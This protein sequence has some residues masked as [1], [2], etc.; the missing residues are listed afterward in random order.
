MLSIWVWPFLQSIGPAFM[1]GRSGC[2]LARI[3][4]LSAG[5]RNRDGLIILNTWD[6]QGNSL[7]HPILK[8]LVDDHWLPYNA[9]TVKRALD[10]Q[11]RIALCT[12]YF[13]MKGSQ[14]PS[15]DRPART[16]QW[17]TW[18]YQVN[19]GVRS[20]LRDLWRKDAHRSTKD[21]RVGVSRSLVKFS[22]LDAGRFELMDQFL[23][24]VIFT[25]RVRGD[26]PSFGPLWFYQG[27]HQRKDETG[28]YGQTDL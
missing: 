16:G 13:Q 2:D 17:L 23:L 6:T 11:N 3:P 4:R 10:Q 1:A 19:P 24:F 25:E 7:D 5:S 26:Q 20:R 27:R 18:F 22:L 9:I 21:R 14:C 28:I 8:Q 15:G 12:N